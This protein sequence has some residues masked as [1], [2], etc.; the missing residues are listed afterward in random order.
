MGRKPQEARENKQ[1]SR[2]INEHLLIFAKSQEARVFFK[3]PGS[4]NN[5]SEDGEILLFEII[6][7][8]QRI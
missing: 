7:N 5:L 2:I 4:N 6:N 8:T 3:H 1:T